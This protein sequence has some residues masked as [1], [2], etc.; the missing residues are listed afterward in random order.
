MKY[1][2]LFCIDFCQTLVFEDSLP[3]FIKFVCLRNLKFRTFKYLYFWLI[4]KLGF[5]VSK[6]NRI[7]L[8]KNLSVLELNSIVT[9]FSKTQLQ[10]VINRNL[11]QYINLNKSFD[12]RIVIVSAAIADYIEPF[13]KNNQLG[14]VIASKLEVKNGITTGKLTEELVFGKL[15]VKMINEFIKGNS[16]EFE[17][18]IAVSDSIHDLPLLE[19]SD[20]PVVIEG[21]CEE[22]TEIAYQRNW[23]MI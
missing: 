7:Y 20:I 8:L 13:C 11:L 19:F 2:K 6:Y 14:D 23:D 18:I 3:L 16:L 12:D 5:K 17:Q 22:L 9:E 21:V 1:P 4:E 10:P 15:K